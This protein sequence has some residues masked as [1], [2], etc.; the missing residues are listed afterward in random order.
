MLL[1]AHGYQV[2]RLDIAD[3]FAE[4]HTITLEGNFNEHFRLYAPESLSVEALEVFNP[5]TMALME[6]GSKRFNVEFCGGRIY[7]Y[8]TSRVNSTG[9]LRSAFNLAKQLVNQVKP[10]AASFQTSAAI[11]T[12]NQ[13]ISIAQTKR[14]NRPLTPMTVVWIAIVMAG[15]VII[16]LISSH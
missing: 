4:K 15:V 1:A 2:G 16:F 12:S 6:D 11:A 10:L 5:E 8:L 9:E 7:I 3:G 14:Q 13:A